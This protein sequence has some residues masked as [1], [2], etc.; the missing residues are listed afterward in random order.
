MAINKKQSHQQSFHEHYS[1]EGDCHRQS[2]YKYYSGEKK[3]PVLTIFIGG[4]H[5]A[6]NHLWEL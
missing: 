4:N 3:A 2:F 1:K 5:E 6:S